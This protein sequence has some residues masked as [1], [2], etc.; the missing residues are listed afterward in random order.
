MSLLTSS[1]FVSLSVKWD[2]NHVRIM[3]LLGESNGM[4]GEKVERAVETSIIIR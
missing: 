2:L 3:D 4:V 1:K